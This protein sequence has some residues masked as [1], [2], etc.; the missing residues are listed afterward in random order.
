MNM[1]SPARLK[2]HPVSIAPSDKKRT[3]LPY[4]VQAE[5]NLFR[6]GDI[7]SGL[8]EVVSGVFRIS[9]LTRGG[10]RYVIGFGFP[11][12]I[13]GYGPDRFHISDCDAV[14]AAKVIRHRA[15]VLYG[16][17]AQL[18]RHQTLVKGALQQVE[19]MQD[20]CMMLGRNTARDRI[21]AFLSLFGER[22]GT[23]LGRYVEFDLLMP[24][25]DIADYL[26][27]STETVSRCLTELRHD[28]LIA[29][30]NVHHFV[31]LQPQHLEELAEGDG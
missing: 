8:F 12:D 5:T 18:Q 6:D 26:G 22:I 11:G 24:R 27:L 9:R 1:L 30:E 20:H 2:A 21:A 17:S 4:C 23:P 29:I 16:D 10:R 15:D 28:N 19:A 31:L 14:S 3:L 25:T 7:C 13:L